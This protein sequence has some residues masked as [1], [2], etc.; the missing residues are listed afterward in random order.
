[1]QKIIS[2]EEVKAAMVVTPRT[3]NGNPVGFRVKVGGMIYDVFT[4][5]RQVAVDR[6]WSRYLKDVSVSFGEMAH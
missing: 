6:A 3:S 1:M 2:D 4:L 5:D